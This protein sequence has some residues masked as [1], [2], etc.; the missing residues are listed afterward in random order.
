MAPAMNIAEH[1]SLGRELRRPGV[2]GHWLRMLDRKTMMEFAAARL[3][4]LD[5]RMQAM[6]RRLRHCPAASVNA[7]PS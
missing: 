7:W 3:A 5:V 2:F 4:D 1:F 6:T